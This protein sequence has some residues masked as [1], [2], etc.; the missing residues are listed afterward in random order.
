MIHLGK[1]I[2][3]LINKGNKKLANRDRKIISSFFYHFPIFG[4]VSDIE[5]SN[6]LKTGNHS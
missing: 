6:T 3:E 5:I 1:V 2:R 4:T